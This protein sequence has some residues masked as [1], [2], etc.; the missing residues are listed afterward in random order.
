MSSR[1][2]ENKQHEMLPKFRLVRVP[3]EIC[4]RI[5]SEAKM[6]RSN[7]DEMTTTQLVMVVLDQWLDENQSKVTTRE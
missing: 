3:I 4:R 7:G 2:S 6:R 5:G 1:A